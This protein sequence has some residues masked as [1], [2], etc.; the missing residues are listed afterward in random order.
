[1]SFIEYEIP[2]YFNQHK[3]SAVKLGNKIIA[4]V[5]EIHP[6]VTNKFNISQPINIFE[7]LVNELPPIKKIENLENLLPMI[8][9]LLIEIFA[10]YLIMKPI[11]LR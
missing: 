3:S 6:L 10:L 4:Y 5:G 8:C 1:M 2:S 7:L 11:L 9:R